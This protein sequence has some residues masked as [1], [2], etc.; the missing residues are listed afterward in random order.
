[1]RR[2]G[3]V[4]LVG[5]ATMAE[6]RNGAFVS[7]DR[8]DVEVLT[9]IAQHSELRWKQEHHDLGGGQSFDV[10][11]GYA[12]QDELV[13]VREWQ[14]Y[15][16]NPE[17]QR[18]GPSDVLRALVWETSPVTKERSNRTESLSVECR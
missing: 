11:R 2:I 7:E 14:R 10:A 18:P 13:P 12:R 15:R 6:P 17:V 5:C 4:A 8:C 16:S 1:M 9:A 3:V